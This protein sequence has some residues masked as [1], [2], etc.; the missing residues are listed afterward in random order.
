ML[1]FQSGLKSEDPKVRSK[2]ITAY[3]SLLTGPQAHTGHKC[4]VDD[5]LPDFLAEIGD[6]ELEVKRCGILTL[7]SALQSRPKRMREVLPTV[8]SLLYA[9]TKVKPELIR[10]IEMGP[11]KTSVDDG[12][13][14]R[15][16]AYEW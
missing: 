5:A 3:R 10:E 1:V 13:E 6:P 7:N 11:F 12:L 2:S 4:L 14:L 9:E 8:V 15:K 16:S